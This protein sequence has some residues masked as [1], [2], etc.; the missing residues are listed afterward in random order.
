MSNQDKA[1]WPSFS[2]FAENVKVSAAVNRVHAGFNGDMKSYSVYLSGTMA[3]QVPAS[4]REQEFND[5]TL[6]ALTERLGLKTESFRDVLRVGELVAVRQAWMQGTLEAMQDTERYAFTEKDRESINEDYGLLLEGMDHPWLQDQLLDQQ[7]LSRNLG[8]WLQEVEPEK[9]SAIEARVPDEVTRGQIVSQNTDFT[10]QSMANGELVT[11]ENRRLSHLPTVG[12]DVTVTYYQGSGQV[13]END[14]NLSVGAPYVDS[15]TQDLAIPITDKAGELK[16][17]VLF[18]GVAAFAKFVEE[19][20]LSASLTEQA[21]AARIASPK[22][23]AQPDRDTRQTLTGIYVDPQTQGLAVDYRE[24]NTRN[25]V[26]FGS[27]KTM[28]AQAKSYGIEQAQVSQAYALES[29]QSERGVKPTIE[30]N[31]VK[32]RGP[33]ATMDE[34]RRYA[35]KA[36]GSNEAGRQEFLRRV[37]EKVAGTDQQAS[38]KKDAGRDEIER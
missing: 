2:E 19:Q 15:K 24:G 30:A 14:K 34:A 26:V 32:A 31:Q 27:A 18:K 35:E 17:V 21:I 8:Q 3:D 29:A 33:V 5:V 16:Q 10:L 4:V 13:F 11:H 9:R 6:E 7:G 23:A 36:F 12:A 1:S 22:V 20:G 37:E 38:K 28:E 25:T